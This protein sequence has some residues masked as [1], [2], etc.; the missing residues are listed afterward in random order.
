MMMRRT[1]QLPPGR[2]M[3][4]V[5]LA[6]TMIM[7]TARVRRARRVGRKG[8]GMGREQMMG[9]GKIRRLRTVKGKGKGRGRESVSG[10]VLLN[11][12]RKTQTKRAN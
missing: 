2:A 7:M 6:M 10:T 8:P 9:R 3:D 12:M 5:F 4:G 1:V 11:C